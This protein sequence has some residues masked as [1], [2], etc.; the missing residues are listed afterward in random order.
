MR[1]IF[2]FGDD[3][4]DFS[5]GFSQ[6]P[7]LSLNPMPHSILSQPNR[8]WVLDTGSLTARLK[9]LAPG[10]FSLQV[11]SVRFARAT[12]SE[13]KALNIPNRQQ[14]YVREVALCIAGKPC[15][16]ARSII[17]RG[18]LTGPERQLLWL[19]NKPLGEYLF[20]HRDMQRLPIQCKFGRINQQNSWARRS[21]FK[22]SGKPLLVSEFFLPA[23]LQTQAHSG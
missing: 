21:I 4:L 18:T 9:S 11:L 23:L 12:L 20:N 8:S 22:L 1:G 3:L 6:Q 7:W 5:N 13:S 10:Q 2:K 15:V 19:K 16:L 17:P 14:V